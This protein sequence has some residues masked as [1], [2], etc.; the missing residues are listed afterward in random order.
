LPPPTDEPLAWD[1]ACKSDL[2]NDEHALWAPW[3]ILI[4]TKER[5]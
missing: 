1:A 4:L 3:S 5:P 2:P